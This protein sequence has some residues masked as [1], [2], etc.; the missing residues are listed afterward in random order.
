MIV[1]TGGTG[2]TGSHL[3]LRLIK[4]KQSVRALIRPGSKP[5]KVLPV[6]GHYSSEANDIFQ[7]IDWYPVD[8]L[9]RASLAEALQGAKQVYHCAATVSFNPRRKHEIWNS[10]INLTRNIVNSCLEQP[11]IKLIHMSSVAAVGKPLGDDSADESC[12]WPVRPGSVYA[13][14]KTLSELEVW[15]GINE[16]LDAVIVNPS[17]IL[18]PGTGKQGSSMIFN[19]IRQGLQ[20]YPSGTT[21]FVDVRDVADIMIQLGNKQITGERFILNAVNLSYKDFFTRV[22]NQFHRKPPSRLV[23]PFMTSIAWKLEWLLTLFTGKEP[24]I[25]RFTSRTSQQKQEYSSE[26]LMKNLNFS[27]RDIDD[28]IREVSDF[29]R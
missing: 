15:R 11:G 25:T 24:R 28:T 19:T 5:E 4:N 14:T 12:C 18:G 10:N 1:V 9:N 22:A 29:Y 3:I 6:W 2:L 26:K 27:F 21:G 20:F 8:M 16:G 13:K 17:V 23:T 7:Q